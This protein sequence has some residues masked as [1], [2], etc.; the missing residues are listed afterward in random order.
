MKKFRLNNGEWTD[1]VLPYCLFETVKEVNE[2]DLRARSKKPIP[3][4]AQLEDARV[5]QNYY[6]VYVSCRYEGEHYNIEATDV[7][8]IVTEAAEEE[9]R[10]M[11]TGW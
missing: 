4:G 2:C 1:N 10:K 3:A 11:R 7:K 9:I 5:F 8:A 6:G